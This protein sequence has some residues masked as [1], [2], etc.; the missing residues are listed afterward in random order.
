M[1]IVS[2][3]VRSSYHLRSVLPVIDPIEKVNSKNKACITTSEPHCP[4]KNGTNTGKY[5]AENCDQSS[6]Y[7]AITP[8][9]LSS[10]QQKSR[11]MHNYTWYNVESFN[12][13]DLP[14]AA[15]KIKK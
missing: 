8:K 3:Y 2:Q 12:K 1:H 4:Y 15:K 5:L 13:M 14:L 11:K 9:L 10:L 6:S 7:Y